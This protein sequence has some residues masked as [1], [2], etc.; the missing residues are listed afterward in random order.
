MSDKQAEWTKRKTDTVMDCL[1]EEVLATFAELGF[2]EAYIQEQRNVL[3][4]KNRFDV[5]VWCNNNL[6]SRCKAVLAEKQGISVEDLNKAISIIVFFD[7]L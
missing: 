5:L 3:V 6:D 1:A 2:D 7:E 4:G